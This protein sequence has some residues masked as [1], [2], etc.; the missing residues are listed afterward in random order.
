[1]AYAIDLETDIDVPVTRVWRA[2]CDPEEV[3]R[4]DTTVIAALNPPADYPQP[5]QHVRWRCKATD[6]LLHDRPQ[7]VEPERRLHSLLEFG[8]QRLDETYHLAPTPSGTHLA[9]HIDLTLTTPL[10]APLLLRLIDGPAVQRAC[11]SSLTNL[12]YYCELTRS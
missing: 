3:V 8:R 2:L 4:W 1:M 9:L 5:G 10:I 12:K 11:E 7:H 6:T